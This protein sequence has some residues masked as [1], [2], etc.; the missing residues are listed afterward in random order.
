MRVNLRTKKADGIIRDFFTAY[1]KGKTLYD[2]YENP[3][4]EKVRTWESIKHT[5]Y[6]ELGGWFL[7]VTGANCYFYSCVYAFWND[8]HNIVI[9]KETHGGTYDVEMTKAEYKEY[10]D[11]YPEI[12]YQLEN[13]RY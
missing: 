2:V 13:G 12:L 11:K 8:A 10:R 9:R 7:H 4:A 3:S 5:C 6:H 1:Y